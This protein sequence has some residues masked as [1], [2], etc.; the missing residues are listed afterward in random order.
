MKWDGVESQKLSAPEGRE[1]SVGFGQFSQRL[2]EPSVAAALRTD[3]GG[4][5][6]G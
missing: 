5:C 3:C 6:G 2:N 1:P 4:A